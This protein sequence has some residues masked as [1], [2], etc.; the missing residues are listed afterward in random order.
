MTTIDIANDSL[1]GLSVG[2]ALGAQFFVPGRSVP[3]L[4]AGRPPAG[5][6]EWTDDTEIA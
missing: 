1:D 2:D 6:W 4:L 3:E 5:P